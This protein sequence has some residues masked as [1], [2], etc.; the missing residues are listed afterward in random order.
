MHPFT[1]SILPAPVHHYEKAK[2]SEAPK[3]KPKKV[4]NIPPYGQRENYIPRCREDYGDGGAFPEIHI[5]QYPLDMGRS[6]LAGE[7]KVV[8]V[9]VDEEGHADYDRN[10]LNQG[11]SA[12]MVVHSKISS[13]VGMTTE[14]DLSRPSEDEVAALT[15]RTREAMEKKVQRMTSAALPGR[16]PEGSLPGDVKPS[17]FYKYTP[18][19]GLTG[20]QLPQRMIRMV[21]VAQDP[22]DPPR[23]RHRKVPAGFGDAPVPIMHSPPRKV[24]VQDQQEWKIPPCVSNWKN[25]RGLTIPLDKRLAADGRSLQQTV[26]NDNFATFAEAMQ[27]AES[28]M[29][30]EVELRNNI[31]RKQKEK[32]RVTQDE[33]MRQRAAEIRQEHEDMERAKDHR[34]TP[35]EREARRQRDKQREEMR[36]QRERDL[37]LKQAGRRTREER[38]RERD[39]SEKIAL[40]QASVA[41]ATGVTFDSRLFDQNGGVQSGYDDDE[42][43]C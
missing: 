25:A 21:E 32:E 1:R 26:V 9:A 37:R 23:F 24:T 40:G 8:S 3:P 4:Y 30:E 27:A 14:Q 41:V 12:A 16:L 10:L 6:E 18:V 15:L 36:R 19:D 2:R 35:A 20:R 17:E 7:T 28:K 13:L 22:L 33:L 5:V 34:E 11:R 43:M 31:L 42:G 39:I 29:R 38:E